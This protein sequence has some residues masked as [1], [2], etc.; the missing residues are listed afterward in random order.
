MRAR[1]NDT[2]SQAQARERFQSHFSVKKVNFSIQTLVLC[3]YAYHGYT[4]EAAYLAA[5]C[6]IS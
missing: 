2:L 3:R 1:Y 5:F 4:Q 6:R